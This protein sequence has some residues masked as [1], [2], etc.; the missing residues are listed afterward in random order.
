MVELI[1]NLPAEFPAVIENVKLFPCAEVFALP[2]TAVIVRIT[3][4]ED[5]DAGI[6]KADPT[7]IVGATLVIENDLFCAKTFPEPSV[8]LFLL[9]KNLYLNL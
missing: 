2:F 6:F 8:T 3:V 1:L 5:V 7:A 4:P 9:Y